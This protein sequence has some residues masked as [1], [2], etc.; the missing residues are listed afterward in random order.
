MSRRVKVSELRAELAR[1]GAIARDL[2]SRNDYLQRAL[3]DVRASRQRTIVTMRDV[4]LGFRRDAAA[5]PGDGNTPDT[6]RAWAGGN[7]NAFEVAAAMLEATATVRATA[8]SRT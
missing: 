6:R 2:S 5:T 1:V 7:A 3:D 4:A 8:A